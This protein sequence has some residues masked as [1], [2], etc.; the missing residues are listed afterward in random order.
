MP[1]VVLI[2]S[3]RLPIADCRFEELATTVQ[4]GNRQSTIGNIK[5]GWGGWIRTNECRF[6]R[7]VPYHLATPQY[8]I[9]GSSPAN[10]RCVTECG[11]QILAILFRFRDCREHDRVP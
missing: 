8:Q 2:E 7:P 1:P 3:L 4:I 11:T 9:A 6:Q 5:V 10:T